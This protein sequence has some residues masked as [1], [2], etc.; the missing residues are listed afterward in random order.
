LHQAYREEA[1]PA[2]FALLTK[3]RSAGVAAF[4]SGAGPTVLVLHTGGATEVAELTQAAGAKFRVDEV[5][6]SA[7]GVLPF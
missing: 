4:I 5:A 3:F 1:M 2:S 7:A 6:I